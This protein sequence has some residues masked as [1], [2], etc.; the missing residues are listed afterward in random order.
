MTNARIVRVALPVPLRRCFDYLVPAEQVTC[1]QPGMR[2]QVP[3]QS[4]KIIGMVVELTDV[5]S[6]PRKKLR[7]IY[8]VLDVQPVLPRDIFQLVLWAAEYYHHPL[9]E[10]LWAALPA[11]LRRSKPA[12]SVELQPYPID[13][14]ELAPALNAAQQQAVSA[15]LA[16]QH[17][18]QVFLLDGVTGS[19]K[20]EVY[21]Q[22]IEEV[23]QQQRQALILVPEISLTPQ[24][25]QR[26]R[27][28]FAVPI[29]AWHSGLSERER[30]AA[31]LAARDGTVR[32]VIGTR[33][34]VFMPFAQLGVIV[35]DEEHDTSF[36]QQ[37][38]FRYHARD[39]AIVRAKTQQIPVILG[40]A[41][42]SLETFYNAGRGRY[43]HLQLPQRAGVAQLPQFQLIDMRRMQVDQGLSVTLVTAMREHLQSGNQVMLFLNRRGYAPILMC[44]ECQ[45]MLEC[46]RC[47]ARMVYHQTTS[48]TWLHCHHCDAHQELPRICEHCQATAFKPIGL[49]TQ[50][51]E[52]ALQKYFPDMPVTRIDRDSTRR[53]GSLQQLFDEIHAAGP[54]ILLG[55]Q[56][57]VKG[58]HFPRVTLVGIIDADAGLF[59]ADF[60]AL[61]RTGQLLLQVAGRAGRAEK[62]GVVYIQTQCPDHPLLQ[63]LIHQGYSTFAAALLSERQAAG[64]PPFAHF[65]L[66]RA[67]AHQQSDAEQFLQEVKN[68]LPA[69]Q[70]RL[71]GPVPALLSQ[72]AG[73]QRMHLLVQAIQRLPVQHFLQQLLP[74][75]EKLTTTQ[76]VR[77]TLDVDPLE[78]F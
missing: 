63:Q 54:R 23:L 35:I 67:E 49:G 45:A 60:R 38:R 50:R 76:R 36:K 33:S 74:Q 9:G 42:P 4:R 73:L 43:Q 12:L 62:H 65:A 78:I 10:V 13:D 37:E 48:R 15:I 29:A 32:I 59:S 6:I 25:L 77:W 51:I 66:F 8:A 31:W 75:L 39:L 47:T 5:S 61:E 69:E 55:T 41:T 70:V 53:K 34:A 7:N 11:I 28:R 64:L 14:R 30:Y 52:K 3:F 22:V 18:F 72:R 16:V 2:V 26:F 46:Q 40:S 20:T 27:Q 1:L 58:H 68:I 19:G 17:T 71:S 21:M 56:M 24:A 57:L 44:S